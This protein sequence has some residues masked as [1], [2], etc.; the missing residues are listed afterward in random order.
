VLHLFVCVNDSARPCSNSL[1]DLVTVIESPLP[2]LVW[3]TY[4][5]AVQEGRSDA[6][7]WIRMEP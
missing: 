6:A 4:F 5:F 2:P 7:A 3:T 1:C